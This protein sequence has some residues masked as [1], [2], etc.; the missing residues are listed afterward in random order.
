MTTLQLASSDDI[1]GCYSGVAMNVVERF[2]LRVNEI[3]HER[4]ENQKSLRGDKSEAWI[5]NIMRG[6]RQLRLRDAE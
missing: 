2:L 4:N 6:S 5:S 3:L 1:S